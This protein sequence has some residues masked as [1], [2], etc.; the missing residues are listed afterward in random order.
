MCIYIYLF[1]FRFFSKLLQDTAYSS[2]C[3]TVGPCSPACLKPRNL[4]LKQPP[5]KT[6]RMPQTWGCRGDRK[7]AAQCCRTPAMSL[8][9][10]IQP[11]TVHD[12]KLA[13]TASTAISPTITSRVPANDCF[14]KCSFQTA[15][16]KGN[17]MKSNA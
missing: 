9:V 8:L 15:L 4:P 2:L 17:K 1:F 13:E 5:V 11:R 10:A 7:W 16:G 14:A 6:Q 12:I 3:Y